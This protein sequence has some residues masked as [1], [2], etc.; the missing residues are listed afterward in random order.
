MEEHSTVVINSFGEQIRRLLKL[1][2][3]RDSATKLISA[4]ESAQVKLRE[5]VYP[6]IRGAE[7]NLSDHG[8]RHIENVEE[9]IV[10][11]LS[12]DGEINCLSAIELYCL[13]MMILFHDTGNVLG[14]ANHHNRIVEIYNSIRGNDAAL[15]RE[16]TLVVKGAKA[17]TGTAQDGSP[18]T[19]KELTDHDHLHGKPVRLR[20][21]AALLRFA[22]E[23]A[24]GP[25]RTS[26]FMFEKDLYDRDSRI[27]HEYAS[28]THI[29]IDRQNGRIVVTFEVQLDRNPDGV[30]RK[31]HLSRLLMFI[32]H[33]ILKLNQ[34][35]Q[36]AKY[37]C[38][39]LQ[40]F[41]MTEVSFN[42]HCMENPIELDLPP[43]RLTDKVVPGEDTRQIAELFPSYELDSLVTDLLARCPEEASV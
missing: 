1:E 28:S 26:S 27:Y 31:D 17:H 37:Y 34:E 10:S 14:R 30:T 41:R 8:S 32:Y 38:D 16:R 20:T 24:E 33:R 23:L 15:L 2:L 39:I 36:Y 6:D 13:G 4:Y 18:D 43:I 19:L 40:P 12:S 42:F 11:L 22:D 7:P 29:W 25:Q 5:Q 9:N 21:L 3:N 35:R